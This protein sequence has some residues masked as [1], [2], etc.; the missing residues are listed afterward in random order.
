MG[1]RK[2]CRSEHSG[3][4]GRAEGERASLVDGNSSQNTPRN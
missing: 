1:L 2:T 4:R 3:G